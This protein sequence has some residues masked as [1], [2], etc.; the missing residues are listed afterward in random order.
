MTFAN[1]Q[2]TLI[3]NVDDYVPGRYARTKLLKQSGF[4]VVE[5]GSGKEALEMTLHLAEN[6]SEYSYIKERC[7]LIKKAYEKHI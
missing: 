3:L 4:P 5:A 6:K 1:S 7:S 2:D